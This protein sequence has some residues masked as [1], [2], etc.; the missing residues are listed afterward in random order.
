ME[1]AD[2]VFCAHQDVRAGQKN[3]RLILSEYLLNA[4]VAFFALLVTGRRKL[5][6]HQVVDLR[7]PRRGGMRLR[8]IPKV[9]P[10]ARKPH[11]D[12]GIWV[13]IEARDPEDTG[14]VFLCLRDAIDQRSKFERHHLDVHPQL[15]QIVLNQ[16]S[17]FR[18]VGVRRA[19]ED[20]KFDVLSIG[21]HEL[22]FSVWTVHPGESGLLQKRT[23]P[24]ERARG[25][26]NRRIH[27]AA[28]PG[29]DWPPKGC[30]TPLIDEP[31]DCFAI[32]GGGHCLPK[33]HFVKPFLLL[34][35]LGRGFVP[36][37]VQ[38]EEKEVVFDAGPDV[39]HGVAA[40][41]A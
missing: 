18:A 8:G 22:R 31:N 12:I 21:V 15:F 28:I 34:R 29:C 20:G 38:I 26:R 41:L 27:P 4:V 13:S 11:V 9:H 30:P 33:L 24:L 39:G 36:K 25:T 19:R 3:H 6:L 17:H 16:G 7:L 37:I 14:I 23:R 5:L 1:I 35:H 32:D 40:L 10:P 2:H